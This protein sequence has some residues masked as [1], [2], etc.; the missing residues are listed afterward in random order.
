MSTSRP[1]GTYS[2]LKS[3]LSLLVAVGMV[4]EPDHK[5]EMK[6]TAKESHGWLGFQDSHGDGSEVKTVYHSQRGPEFHS[7]NLTTTYN[8]SF[9]R[10]NTLF[11]LPQAPLNRFDFSFMHTHILKIK[12]LKV[13]F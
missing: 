6:M 3:Q 8:P 9:R 7:L 4:R 13:S 2:F 1:V 12:S 5:G 11:W 10:L